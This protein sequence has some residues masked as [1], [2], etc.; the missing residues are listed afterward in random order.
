MSHT[1][2]DPVSHN[3]NG[4][5]FDVPF[6]QAQGTNPYEIVLADDHRLLRQGLRML[7]ESVDW[8]KVV[9]EAADGLDLLDLLKRQPAHM[10][11]LD[12]SMPRLHGLEAIR[13]IRTIR[14]GIKVL[15]LTMHNERRYL[16][17]AMAAGADG[18]LL[19]DD[20]DSELFSAIER[21]R[22]G[23]VYVSPGFREDVIVEWA[24]GLRSPSK[25]QAEPELL[26]DRERQILKLIAEGRSNRQIA[27]L[28][29]ISVRTAEHHR[30]NIR[31][32]LNVRTTADLIK[33]AGEKG[34]I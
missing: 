30:A 26:T 1:P 29:Y 6:L 9:G 25:P 27:G 33:Y 22:D 23:R 7:I 19:K 5:I 34:F 10:V 12:L 28:L 15:V 3:G 2:F 8:L 24:R 16:T 11:L 31:K 4:T 18:Y 21:V 32:K 17:D 20:A 14:P 13:E